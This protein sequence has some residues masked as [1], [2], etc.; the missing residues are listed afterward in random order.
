MA[1]RALPRP[2]VGRANGRSQANEHSR[3]ARPGVDGHGNWL[4]GTRSL[5]EDPA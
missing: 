2:D 3:I 4:I 1:L 5:V